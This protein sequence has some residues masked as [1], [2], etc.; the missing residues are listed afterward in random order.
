MKNI[1]F[2]RDGSKSC[3]NPLPSMISAV[4]ELVNGVELLAHVLLDHG[5]AI[6]M[7]LYNSG[8]GSLAAALRCNININLSCPIV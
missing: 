2:S 6:V 8:D 4:V 7:L 5:A 3:H 1:V